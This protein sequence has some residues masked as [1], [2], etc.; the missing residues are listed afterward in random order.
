[1][2]HANHFSR[3]KLLILTDIGGDPDDTQSMVRLVLYSNHFDIVGL[4]ATSRMGHGADTQAHIIRQIVDDFALVHGNLQAHARHARLPE[5]PAAET[6]RAVIKSGQPGNL[7]AAGDATSWQVPF[8]TGLSTEASEHIIRV[9]DAASDEAPVHISIWGGPADLAQ[10][11]F[12]VQSQR[13]PA[14]VA[15]FVAKIR[16]CASSDQDGSG[17]WI[18]ARFPQLLYCLSCDSRGADGKV[19]R[20][21]ASGRGM[22]QNDAAR[23]DG[24]AQQ[25]VRDELLP[26]VTQESVERW[27]CD[28][29]GSKPVR[30][31]Y[32]SDE[33]NNW[34]RHGIW[35][36]P[37]AGFPHNG[38]NGMKEGDTP[39]W[40]YFLRNGLNDEQAPGAGGWGGRYQRVCDGLYEPTGDRHWSRKDGEA[41]QVAVENTWAVARWR[42]DAFNDFVARL[43]WT[44][45]GEPAAALHAPLILSVEGRGSGT[46]R[47]GERVRLTACAQDVDGRGLHYEW[48]HYAEAGTLPCRVQ[49]ESTGSE[50]SFVVPGAT[51]RCTLHVILRVRS[52][53]DMPLSSY[54]R[55]VWEVVT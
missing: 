53:A 15:D 13:P 25:L 44:E 54:A 20:Y 29:S 41:V 24:T 8:G 49:I 22:Y 43:R 17:A 26:L 1:M 7:R 27:I 12:D 50:A 32:P 31:L 46:L 47:P 55:L 45:S 38:H 9:V 52:D 51:S 11:L 23:N 6:L 35:R 28:R 21:S 33:T 34:Q 10:A 19:L 40:F 36:G 39:T 4:I 30:R 18:N 16:V 3:P 48:F 37:T 5:Y 14:Q 2:Q 42:E